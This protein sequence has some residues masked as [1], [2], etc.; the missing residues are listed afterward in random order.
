MADCV[1]ELARLNQRY[2]TVKTNP[3]WDEDM[4]LILITA[5]Y[6]VAA[7]CASQAFGDE[8]WQ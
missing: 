6:D 2:E 4:L 3:N 1:D 7:L 8:P 5:Q